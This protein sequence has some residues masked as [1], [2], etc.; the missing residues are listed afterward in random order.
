[1]AVMRPYDDLALR[2][3]KG[4]DTLATA[5]EVIGSRIGP[6]TRFSAGFLPIR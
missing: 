3:K 4:F 2:Y 1:M 5:R 6:A